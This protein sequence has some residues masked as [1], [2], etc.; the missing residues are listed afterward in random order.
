MNANDYG[1]VFV[2]WTGGFNLSAFTSLELTF[3]KP[4]GTVL[5]VMN[6]AVSISGSPL[7]TPL[8]VLDPDTYALYTFAAGDIN[9]PGQYGVRLTYQSTGVQLISD[10]TVFTVSP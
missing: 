10:P 4:N 8:G 5:T 6:P 7:T 1:I 3:T 9:L 2:F